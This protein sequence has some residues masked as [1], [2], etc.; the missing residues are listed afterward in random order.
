MPIPPRKGAGIGGFVLMVDGMPWRVT[1]LGSGTSTGVPVISC[2]C[3]VCTSTNPLNHRLRSSIMLRRGETTIVVD[4]GADFRAQA[5]KHRIRRLDALLLTHAHSDHVAGMDELR[6][7]NWRQGGPVTVYTSAKTLA[8]LRKRFDYIFEPCQKGG[9]VSQ[10]EPVLVESDPFAAAGIAVLPLPVMHGDLAV[11]GFRFGDFAYITDA[12]RVPEATIKRLAGVRWLI[13]NALRHRPH[14]THLTVEQAVAI[15]RRVGAERT[16]FTH[17]THD[18]DHDETNRSLPPGMSLAWDG[19]EFDI[20][21]AAP[22][23]VV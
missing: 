10:I 17:I 1:V 14:P 2:D 12:S 19:L 5:L 7:F 22:M 11:L 4:C 6:L 18:L 9:G 13:L 20:D 21:A 16:W 3:R 23:P 15:A 8:G